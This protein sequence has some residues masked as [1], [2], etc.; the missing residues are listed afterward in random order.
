MIKKI[1]N[2]FKPRTI[3]RDDDG[4]L[5]A[6][7]LPYGWNKIYGDAV[8]RY[9]NYL[10]PLFE[11]AKEKSE[12]QFILTL[13]RFRGIQPTR[14]DSY[15]N[16]L[17]IFDEIMKIKEKVRGNTKLNLILWLYGHIVEASEPYET[18]AN[19]LNICLGETYRV[20]NFPKIKTRWGFRPQFPNEKI[21]TLEKM[22]NKAGLPD[23]IKP[24][25]EIFD[26]DLRNAVF[27]SDYSVDDGQIILSNS[28]PTR[29]YNQ[30]ETLELT[31]KA[32]AY[33]ECIRNLIE[34]STKGYNESK[35]ITADRMSDN[36]NEKA[37]LIIRE[38]YGVIAMKDAFTKEQIANGEIPWFVGKSYT[39]ERKLI[40]K[41]EY[42][43]PKDRIKFWNQVLRK[44]PTF[45]GKLP[46][47]IID[48]YIVN[49]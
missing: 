34:G 6:T 3:P 41:G 24:I 43:L 5:V 11:K 35:V 37:T 23:V 7:N 47:N 29:I 44:L 46:A 19:L 42:L 25:K 40:D 28:N 18:I 17:E 13:F 1:I 9:L 26:K 10:E 27:H 45:I 22:A 36:P 8:V 12:F 39:Y 20:G 48:R 30:N 21:I 16:S 14:W 31:N 38:G 32:M 2:I 33:H 49:R 15:E 4:K